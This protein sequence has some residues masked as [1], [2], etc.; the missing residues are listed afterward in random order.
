[1]GVKILQLNRS[2]SKNTEMDG[3]KREITESQ[4]LFE[5]ISRSQAVIEFNMDGTIITANE[6]FLSVVGYQ[7]N[8]IQGRHHSMFFGK[9]EAESEEYK[10]FWA[11]LHNG[12]YQARAFKR[13]GKDGKEIWIQASYNPI[14]NEEGHPYKVVKFATDITESRLESINNS[15]Q[16]EAIHRSQ[17]VIEFNMDGTIITANDNFLSTMGYSLSEIQGKH[18]SMFATKEYAKSDEYQAFWEGLRLG[19]YKSGEFMRMGRDNKEVW[20]QASYNPV[21]DLNGKPY[22]VVKFASDITDQKQMQKTVKSI[23]GEVNDVMMALSSGDVD[24]RVRGEY[25]GQFND[26]KQ[27]VNDYCKTIKTLVIKIREVA[28]EARESSL[29]N[30]DLSRRTESL[31]TSIEEMSVSMEEMTT[32]VKQN[33]SNA[34]EASELAIETREQAS[35]GGDVVSKAVVAMG[36]INQSSSKIADIIGVIDE[37]AFQTNLLAL[38]AAVEVQLLRKKLK[39]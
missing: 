29:G 22:K 13:F 19:Q 6:N 32:T 2:R 24:K 21:M 12:Q 8:E 33:A 39:N 26:L 4:G 25:T 38:N 34:N 35:A 16:I 9:S 14:L 27:A 20:I 1:M 37:I 31:A 10:G 3:L 18:H 11:S 7:L 17:A 5:A 15:A 36:D 28:D 23:L 30:V